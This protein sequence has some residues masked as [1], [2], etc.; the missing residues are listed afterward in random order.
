MCYGIIVDI[1][2]EASIFRIEVEYV[3]NRPQRSI[4][5]KILQKCF[6]IISFSSDVC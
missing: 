3:E 4:D 1:S 5:A 2:S 6:I